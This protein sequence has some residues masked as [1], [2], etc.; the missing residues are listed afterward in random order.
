MLSGHQVAIL[1][2]GVSLDYEPALSQ[3]VQSC[4]KQVVYHLLSIFLPYQD[5]F[6]VFIHLTVYVCIIYERTLGWKHLIIN[7]H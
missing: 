6:S 7:Y 3:V 2:L 5:S 4:L 1:F